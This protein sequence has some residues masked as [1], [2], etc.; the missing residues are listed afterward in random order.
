MVLQPK[1]ICVGRALNATQHNSKRNM[2]TSAHLYDVPV[3]HDVLAAGE[4][5]TRAELDAEF[6]RLHGAMLQYRIQ[7]RCI[8]AG[9]HRHF[10]S[11][12]QEAAWHKHT[13]TVTLQ[14]SAMTP[15][16]RAYLQKSHNIQYSAKGRGRTR[17]S[18]AGNIMCT[19]N[20]KRRTSGRCRKP[21]EAIL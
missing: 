1:T 19:G 20:M 14:P 21:K 4:D 3:P 2:T 6:Q 18:C 12:A 15:C 7:Q 13:A 16:I 17:G 11:C 10:M 5:V 8:Q 9:V